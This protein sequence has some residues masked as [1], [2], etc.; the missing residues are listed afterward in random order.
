M[1]ASADETTFLKWE[2]LTLKAFSGISFSSEEEKQALIALFC[3]VAY[4]DGSVHEK[5]T[6]FIDKISDAIGFE[7]P[8][9]IRTDENTDK[10]ELNVTSSFGQAAEAFSMLA[11]MITDALIESGVVPVN[12]RLECQM[13]AGRLL[14]KNTE[15]AIAIASADDFA[16]MES[17]L[18][19]SEKIVSLLNLNETANIQT[20][21]YSSTVYAG[22]PEELAIKNRKVSIYASIGLISIFGFLFSFGYSIYLFYTRDN[23]F[24]R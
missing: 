9:E 19:F 21:G 22:T 3:E 5:E 17:F 18:F 4:A 11:K 6:Q 2:N 24:Y 23:Q 7:N 8:F 12:R 1:L 14:L 20:K 10:S 15:K 13:V 16:R